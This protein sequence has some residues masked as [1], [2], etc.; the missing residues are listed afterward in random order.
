[1][2]CHRFF[3]IHPA[4]VIFFAYVIDKLQDLEYNNSSYAK[5]IPDFIFRQSNF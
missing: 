2:A 4:L 3:G 5:Y 1:M